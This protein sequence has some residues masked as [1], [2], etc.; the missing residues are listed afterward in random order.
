MIRFCVLVVI[1]NVFNV[2]CRSLSTTEILNEESKP[3][4]VPLTEVP[5]SLSSQSEQDDT[6]NDKLREKKSIAPNMVCF[7]LL[8][9]N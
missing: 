7:V 2:D 3:T 1:L 5:L 6:S 9:Q 4:E 8:S